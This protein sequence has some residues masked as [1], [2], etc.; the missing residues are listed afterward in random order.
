MTILHNL[1][2]VWVYVLAADILFLATCSLVFYI[3]RLRRDVG[4]LRCL[5][6]ADDVAR[7]MVDSNGHVLAANSRAKTFWRGSEPDAE[8]ARRIDRA[9]EE[10]FGALERLI[11]AVARRIPENVD[12]MLQ[13]ERGL[14]EWWRIGVC[15]APM[16]SPCD[17]GVIWTAQDV[18]AHRAIEDIL[19]RDRDVQAEFLYLMPAGLYSVDA[20]EQLRFVNQRLAD[21]L[22]YSV[23]ELLGMPLSRILA[24]G[25]RPDA[26][27]AWSGV[28]RFCDRTGNIFSAMVEQVAFD[29]AGETRTRSVV[30]RQAHATDLS[31]S[32]VGHWFRI[33]FASL[34]VGLCLVDVEGVVTD[35]NEAFLR[36]CGYDASTLQE[37]AV[38]NVLAED[39]RAAW[40]A[41]FEHAMLDGGA[42]ANM[43]REVHFCKCPDKAASIGIVP[44]GGALF[45][46]FFFDNTAHRNLEIQFAQA[47]KMQAM[48]QL[49]GGVAHDFNNLLTAMIGFCDLLLQRHGAGDPSFADLMQIKQN[50][51]RAANLVRQLLA[52]SRKQPLRPR[53]VLVTD[54]LTEI[55]HL[56]RRLLGESIH[57]ELRLGR[58]VG[59][60]RVDP[61][62]LDQVIINLAVNARDAMPGGGRLSIETRREMVDSAM[63]VGAESLSAGEYAVITV[64]D[65]GTGISR[66]NLARI[67]EPFFSTKTGSVGAGTGLGLS[68]VYGIVR[69]TGGVILVD[70]SVGQ[71]TRFIIYLPCA[72]NA[73]IEEAELS[74]IGRGGTATLQRQ[75]VAKDLSG[76]A[77]ILLVEDE[78]AVRV[79]ASRALRNKGYRVVEACSGEQALEK[80]ADDLDIDL[81]VTDM[82][83]PGMDGATLAR[84]VKLEKPEIQVILI[85]GYS[86]EA[87]GGGIA[88]STEFSFLPKPF[89]L[90]QLAERVHA[91]LLRRRESVNSV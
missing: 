48:G 8:L 28:L 53:Q 9:D 3:R 88:D 73:V 78:D 25:S 27:E 50:A 66:E 1:H 45:M 29:D 11:S 40:D 84:R 14:A 70:S 65:T 61:G 15:P 62:Q 60:I 37:T 76:S 47:Q 21:W 34:P 16:T 74:D 51:N 2:F 13:G 80:L 38:R 5:L 75:A 35:A 58:D 22:G 71:G 19:R 59:T 72:D 36:L 12:V 81:L 77:T 42:D 54:A 30:M 17:G 69:Q 63:V 55:S 24:D 4:C 83:M 57:L 32:P 82:V 10:T 85:S 52:F 91:V 79:F 39:D 7:L 46:A 26:E 41:L 56:L 23:N 43:A 67:F 64:S 49:A 31:C 6:E 86:E 90:T 68:T 89:S 20:N 18:T 87:A 33:I 44:L